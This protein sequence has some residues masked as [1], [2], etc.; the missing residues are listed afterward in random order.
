MSD[1]HEVIIMP[2]N[3]LAKKQEEPDISAI[4]IQKLRARGMDEDMLAI[5][6]LDV[7]QNAEVMNS[8][9]DVITDYATKLQAIKTLHKMLTRQPENQINIAAVFAWSNSF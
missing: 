2:E 3:P 6:L 5:E 8:K 4:L 7:I 9:G 1:E